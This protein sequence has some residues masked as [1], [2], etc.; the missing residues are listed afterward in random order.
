MF[1]LILLLNQQHYIEYDES[2]D[3]LINTIFNKATKVKIFINI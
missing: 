2:N 3:T 1:R